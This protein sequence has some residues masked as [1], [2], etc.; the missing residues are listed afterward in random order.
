MPRTLLD[1]DKFFL[2]LADHEGGAHADANGVMDGM[3]S[4]VELVSS[5][6]QGIWMGRMEDLP[7]LKLG[8]DN[9]NG[10]NHAKLHERSN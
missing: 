10:R 5:R 8:E 6:M 3:G 4:L 9:E 2:R 1:I 7:W